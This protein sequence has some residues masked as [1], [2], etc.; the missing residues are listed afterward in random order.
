MPVHV[1]KR[2]PLPHLTDSQLKALTGLRD[3]IHEKG[4]APTWMELGERLGISDQAAGNAIKRLAVRGLVEM[5]P[6]TK[7]SLVITERGHRTL[8]K[9]HSTE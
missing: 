4:F 5:I 8:R 9:T 2:K 7:R 3:S 6:S 1:G